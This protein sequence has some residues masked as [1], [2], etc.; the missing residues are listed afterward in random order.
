MRFF[1]H[2]DLLCVT[3]KKS[4]DADRSDCSGRLRAVRTVKIALVLLLV[5]A[6]GYDA[7]LIIELIKVLFQ[8]S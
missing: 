3:E 2:S 6:L 5:V 7:V 1:F 4:P 8:D